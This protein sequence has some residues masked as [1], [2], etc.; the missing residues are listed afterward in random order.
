MAENEEAI[1]VEA[2]VV[3]PIAP[4]DPIQPGADEPTEDD[5]EWDAVIDEFAPGLRTEKKE[6]KQEDKVD[7]PAKPVE[8][9]KEA[10]KVEID[11]NETPEAK[12]AREAKE[13]ADAAN[14]DDE[15]AEEPDTS[16]R[17]IRVSTREAQKQVEA[18]AKDVREKMF[19][20][21][22]TVLQ[23]AEGDPITSVADVMKLIN[24]RTQEA[25]TEEEAGM[26]LLSAQQQFNVRLAQMDKQIEQIAEVNVDLKDQ[27]DSITYQYGELLKA[28]PD[29]RDQ[30]WVEYQ[31]TLVKDEKSGI[32]T[33]A[34]VSLEKFYDI[35]LQPYVKL[36]QSLETQEGDVA[37]VEAERL[38]AEEEVKKVK[39]RADRSDIYGSGK[40]DTMD[41]DE[42]EWAE[43]AKDY[44]EN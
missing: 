39:T 41:D 34:P 27:A 15:E 17:D 3:E 18:V 40:T 32:I 12:T 23:D 4:V 31:K 35:A 1:V 2:P 26:W 8:K 21:A 38:K 22:P 25:F 37:K 9:P 16:A 10:E 20:D 11:P 14:K 30:L 42:K 29:L 7:E 13:A 28:M 6:S 33:A 43:A 44:Y 24:P 5:K 36:A 19:A